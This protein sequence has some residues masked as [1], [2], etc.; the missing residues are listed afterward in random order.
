MSRIIVHVKYF[1]EVKSR[2]GLGITIVFRAKKGVDVVVIRTDRCQA[3][4]GLGRRWRKER[5]SG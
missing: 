1:P 4:V 2:Q 3:V 5:L